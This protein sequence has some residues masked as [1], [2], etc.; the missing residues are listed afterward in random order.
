MNW[1]YFGVILVA[2]ASGTEKAP[3]HSRRRRSALC[4]RFAFIDYH[5]GIY[6]Y[7]SKYVT[8]PVDLTHDAI[9]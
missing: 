5:A 7:V 6:Q 2:C 9:L 4:C 1:C 3:Y 8:S